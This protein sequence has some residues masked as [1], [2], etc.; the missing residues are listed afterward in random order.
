[1][2]LSQ[3][4]QYLSVTSVGWQV[5]LRDPMASEFP[6]RCGRSDCELLYPYRPTLLYFLAY[7]IG[8]PWNC[9]TL[10]FVLTVG[11]LFVGHTRDLGT[12]TWKI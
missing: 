3:Y 6:Q 5:T 10:E 4:R 7:F 2:S 12:H 8:R 9:K 11:L 1:M